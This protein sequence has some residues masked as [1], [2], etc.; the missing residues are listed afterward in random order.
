MNADE[1][2]KL[3]KEMRNLKKGQR[4]KN[5]EFKEVFFHFNLFF[6]IASK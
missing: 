3:L 4:T 6:T 1:L 5:K 2:K